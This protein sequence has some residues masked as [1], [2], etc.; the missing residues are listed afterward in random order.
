[1]GK[2]REMNTSPARR[3]V[4][5]INAQFFPETLEYQCQSSAEIKVRALK[6]IKINVF[7]SVKYRFIC[8]LPNNARLFSQ[9]EDK[10]LICS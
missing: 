4:T 1:M 5:G 7:H 6:E 8:F 10:C 9:K 3:F 2:L